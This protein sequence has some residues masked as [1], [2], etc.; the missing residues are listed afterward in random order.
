MPIGHRPEGGSGIRN[1]NKK[2]RRLESPKEG[3]NRGGSSG[4]A[5]KAEDKGQRTKDKSK[6]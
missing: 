3:I 5:L 4:S 1:K 2:P 6:G